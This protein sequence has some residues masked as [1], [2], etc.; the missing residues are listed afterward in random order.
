M[1][2]YHNYAQYSLDVGYMNSNP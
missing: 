1:F 2:A